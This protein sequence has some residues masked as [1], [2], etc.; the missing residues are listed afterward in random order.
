VNERLG[1]LIQRAIGTQ[2]ATRRAW[3]RQTV[4]RLD[5]VSFADPAA[6]GYGWDEERRLRHLEML[7]NSMRLVSR[8]PLYVFSRD[9]TDLLEI[10]SLDVPDYELSPLDPRTPDGFVIFDRPVHLSYDVKLGTPITADGIG[11]L[12]ANEATPPELGFVFLRR[13]IDGGC[14]PANATGF[15][16][17]VYGRTLLAHLNSGDD[18]APSDWFDTMWSMHRLLPALFRLLHERVAVPYPLDRLDR[19]TRR[20]LLRRGPILP[21]S[22]SIW[23]LREGVP[24]ATD[25]AADWRRLQHRHIVRKHW[26]AYW[27]GSGTG[28]RIVPHLLDA[29]IQG[30]PGTPI[31]A[32]R[33]V[34]AVVR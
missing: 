33:R 25:E 12:D 4:E 22:L 28:R 17:W 20:A 29:Y 21:G 26:H 24:R 14:D 27:H 2:D 32:R 9:L 30:P 10:A 1:P 23:L 19:P 5:A 6:E 31:I 7:M 15:A 18:P 8:A 11:W 34:G 13:D 3:D 16:P